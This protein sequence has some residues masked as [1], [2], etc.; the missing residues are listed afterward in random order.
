M[1]KLVVA[2][3]L[4]CALVLVAQAHEKKDK[5]DAKA[6][7]KELTDKYDTNKDGKIDKDEASKMSA[8]DKEKYEK[9][10]AARKKKKSQ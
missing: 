9:M 6:A 5:G 10:V 2:L 3:C 8:E 4:T 7:R 1:K